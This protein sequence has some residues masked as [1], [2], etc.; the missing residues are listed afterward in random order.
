MGLGEVLD[1]AWVHCGNDIPLIFC[2]REESQSSF[3][4]ISYSQE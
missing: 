3:V 1:G 4:Y 2:A